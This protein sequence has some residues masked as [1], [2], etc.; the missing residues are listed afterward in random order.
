MPVRYGGR[1]PRIKYAD[2][3]AISA[4]LLQGFLWR[5]KRKSL[6][7]EFNPLAR[8]YSLGAGSVGVGLLA[9]LRS[10]STRLA[11][12]TPLLKRGLANLLVVLAGCCPP[13]YALS[14]DM[15]ENEAL[16]TQLE[17]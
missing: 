16:E 5:L 15:R 17:E 13:L 3:T 14:L 7:T 11:A 8:W 1:N 2:S 6:V 10:L 12:E 9:G 4:M